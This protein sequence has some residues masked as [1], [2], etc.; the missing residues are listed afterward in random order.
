MGV[1][2]KGNLKKIIEKKIHIKTIELENLEKGVKKKTDEINELIS[3]LE[4]F[5][6]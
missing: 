5:H 6:E 4:D 1:Y 3:K 2:N